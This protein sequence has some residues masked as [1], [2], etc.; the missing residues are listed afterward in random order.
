M[1]AIR[2]A[3]RWLSCVH[4][5]CASV[6]VRHSRIEVGIDY[7]P[8]VWSVGVEI[9]ILCFGVTIML[10]PVSVWANFYGRA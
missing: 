5:H 7:E 3:L 8:F 2:K 1:G 9:A 10:G 6:W 4:F